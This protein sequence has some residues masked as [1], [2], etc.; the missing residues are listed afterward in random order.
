MSGTGM[1]VRKLLSIGFGVILLAL[2]G[3]AISGYWGLSSVST[4]A[5]REF[6]K[7]LATNAVI[8]EHSEE[9]AQGFSE[10]GAKRMK[11]IEKNIEDAAGRITALI[12]ILSLVSI[13]LGVV[14]AL[15]IGRYITGSLKRIIEGLQNGADQVASASVQVSSSSRTLAEGASEQ[16]ASVEETSSS[17]EEVS[18]T[19]RQNA[20][21]ANEVNTMMKGASHIVGKANQS[22]Q[23]LIGSME[24]IS[25]ASEE[26]SKIIKTIDEIA[27]QTNLLA[28]NAAVEAARAGEAG[29]GFA[30]VADE[31]RNLALR[32]AEAA[33]NTA[34][35]IEGSVEKIKGGADLVSRTNKAFSK[36]AKSAAKVGE[37][38]AEIAA[39]SNEQAQGIEQV[40]KAIAEMDRVIQQ[41]AASAEESSSAAEEM[42]AQAEQMRGMV[43]EMVALVGLGKNFGTK[44]G[45]H[46][47]EVKR[48][49]TTLSLSR[50]AQITPNSNVGSKEVAV[51]NGRSE[52]RPEDAIP[53]DEQDFKN[54]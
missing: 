14:C 17:L 32:T 13:A 33:R 27:F 9:A 46:S 15:L 5:I 34:N 6:R 21:H 11:Q 47:Q 53:L 18:S 10:E 48:K 24:E 12:S 2:I 7:V 8:T 36:V 1:N 19:T 44:R 28:L 37:L 50:K 4:T 38:V 3:I 39:A 41:N 42:N 52:I 49:E 29:A 54:F 20:D 51:R 26:T 45:D 35:L 23:E 43:G 16:A 30:V 25:R 31:V 22:M 40:N